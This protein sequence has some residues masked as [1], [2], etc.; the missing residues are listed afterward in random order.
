MKRI[1]ILSLAL[2]AC[3]KNETHAQPDAAVLPDA[4]I[5]PQPANNGNIPSRHRPQREIRPPHRI[6]G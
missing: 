2:V 5:P 3:G 4:A 1:I 6:A